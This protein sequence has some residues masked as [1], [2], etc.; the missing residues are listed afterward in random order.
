MWC[1]VMEKRM[2]KSDKRAEDRCIENSTDRRY[3]DTDVAAFCRIFSDTHKNTCA[4]DSRTYSIWNVH[5]RKGIQGTTS[6]EKPKKYLP[7]F[8]LSDSHSDVHNLKFLLTMAE[9]YSIIS[10]DK[11][12]QIIAKFILKST[13]RCYVAYRRYFYFCEA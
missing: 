2:E 4:C 10:N 1:K 7:S 11:N 5:H 3:C 8:K 9:R 13:V 6:K 12:F